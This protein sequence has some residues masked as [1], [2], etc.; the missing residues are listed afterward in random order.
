MLWVWMLLECL[1]V[2]WILCM[3]ARM[4]MLAFSFGYV[5]MWNSYFA[6]AYTQKIVERPNLP[7][8][9]CSKHAIRSGIHQENKQ[10]EPWE[11]WKDMGW[12]IMMKRLG[13]LGFLELGGW[14]WSTVRPKSQ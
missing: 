6:G 11:A 5:L 10:M 14:L 4:N 3:L 8:I 13:F 2:S 1:V 12:W 9:K 7:Y